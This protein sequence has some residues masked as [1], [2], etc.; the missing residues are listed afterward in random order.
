MHSPFSLAFA[1]FPCEVEELALSCPWLLT[2]FWLLKARAGLTKPPGEEL[3]LPVSISAMT[4]EVL[5]RDRI[6]AYPQDVEA[7]LSESRG[8][9]TMLKLVGCEVSARS[10]AAR[11]S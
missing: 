11:F 7:L 6:F 3:D 8:H 4:S 10:I 5:S 1:A 9:I 2:D